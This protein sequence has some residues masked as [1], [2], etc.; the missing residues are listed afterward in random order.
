MTVAGERLA[1]AAA[2]VRGF[3]RRPVAWVALAVSAVLLTFGGGA[4]M[5]WFHAIFRGEQGPAI[6]DVHHWLLDSSLGFAA[7]TPVLALILPLGVWAAGTGDEAGRA[8]RRAYVGAVAAVFT[9]VTGPGPFLHNLVAGEGTPLAVLATRAFG[10]D[11]AVAARNLHIHDRSPLAEGILQVVVGFPVYLLCTWFGLA[12]V[13]SLVR[14]TRR[15]GTAQPVDE[16][17]PRWAAVGPGVARAHPGGR[18]RRR[19]RRGSAKGSSPRERVGAAA[20]SS[21]P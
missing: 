4:V 19:Q 21:S 6:A 1:D 9:L 11:G 8:G 17:A 16:P 5:F 15:A 3:Y 20:A 2:A 12:L 10:H 13:R 14:R 18:P 7:L